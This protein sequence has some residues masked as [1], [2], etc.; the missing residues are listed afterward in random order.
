MAIFPSTEPTTT[1]APPPCS[2]KAARRCGRRSRPRSRWSPRPGRRPRRGRPRTARTRPPRRRGRTPP[3]PAVPVPAARAAPLTPAPSATSVGTTR[4]SAPRAR[5]SAPSA[6]RPSAERAAST[7]RLPAAGQPSAV[8]RPMPL[9]APA[10]RTT[11]PRHG[12]EHHLD[13]VVLLLLEDLVAVRR[14]VQREVVGGQVERAERVGVVQDQRQDL[15]DPAPHVALPHPHQTPRSNISIIGIGSTSP[16]YTPLTETVPP[17]R[18]ALS[19]ASQRGQPV[20]GHRV[21]QRP[22][23]RRPA[24]GRRVCAALA[25]GEPCASMP[26]ASMTPSG[27]RP[28]VSSIRARGDVVDVAAVDGLDAVPARPAPAARAPGRRR[29]PARRPGGGRSARELADRAEPEHR[30]GAAAGHLGVLHRLPGGGQD[31]GEVEEPLV[32]RLR[33]AP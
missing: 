18:T 28:P 9:D 25:T 29:S 31:V 6:S 21:G 16:P 33:P 30:E 13:A 20:D 2:R 26:T 1:R 15:L 24:A 3:R 8:A 4:L 17:R 14:L 22:G 27:P 32:G 10:T 19:A 11:R 5:H 12:V 23:E 7:S